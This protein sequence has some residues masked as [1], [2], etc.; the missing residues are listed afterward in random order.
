MLKCS[1]QK[2]LNTYIRRYKEKIEQVAKLCEDQPMDGL[3]KAVWWIEY[4]TRHKGTKHLRSPLVDLPIY[5]LYYIDVLGV[6]VLVFYTLFFSL[7]CVAD[8]LF[9]FKNVVKMKTT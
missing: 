4:V 6:S 9:R 7:K 1:Q 5:Q 3:E 2:E 8:K